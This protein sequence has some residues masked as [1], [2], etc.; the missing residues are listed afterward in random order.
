[1][2]CSKCGNKQE[3]GEKFCPQCGNPFVIDEHQ[4]PLTDGTLKTDIQEPSKTITDNKNEN[5][6]E[7]SKV[8]LFVTFAFVI[9][10]I[11]VGAIYHDDFFYNNHSDEYE[12]ESSYNSSQEYLIEENTE[13]KKILK[14]IAG[15]YELV[16]NNGIY[17]FTT[18]YTVVIRENGTGMTVFNDGS[19][20]NFYEA[21]LD[22]SDRIVFSGDYGGTPFKISGPGIE[23]ESALKEMTPIGTNR[24]V[25]RKIK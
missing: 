14:R 2:Y 13:L 1:M 24:Y 16:E 4:I 23:D 18:V 22:G 21:H 11:I 10:L 9:S 17:G 3:E 19:T 20:E 15:T 8:G 7:K 12:Y 25:M 5:S 6:V